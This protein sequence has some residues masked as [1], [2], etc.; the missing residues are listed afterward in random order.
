M[1]VC[2]DTHTIIAFLLMPMFPLS[3]K[4][5]SGSFP[6]VYQRAAAKWTSRFFLFGFPLTAVAAR[7]V[8]NIAIVVEV[9]FNP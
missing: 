9:A 5:W 7:K 2:T 3:K 1:H 8:S 4:V 6:S